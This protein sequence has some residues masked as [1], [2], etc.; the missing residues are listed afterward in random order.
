MHTAQSKCISHN[1]AVRWNISPYKTASKYHKQCQGIYLTTQFFWVIN[2][3][4]NHNWIYTYYF[5]ICENVSVISWRCANTIL[6]IWS[7]TIQ[8]CI[9]IQA[10][11]HISQIYLKQN[12]YSQ[13]LSDCIMIYTISVSSQPGVKQ[14]MTLYDSWI[15]KQ[16]HKRE[17]IETQTK[18]L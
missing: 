10:T 17:W 4:F 11:P 5:W 1:Q 12:N 3:W 6:L 9:V 7:I 8:D 2:N 18:H 16:C 14:V 13:I 15:V